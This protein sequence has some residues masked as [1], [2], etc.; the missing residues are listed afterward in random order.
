MAF[1]F[2]HFIGEQPDGEQVYFSVSQDGLHWIDL[3][4]GKPVLKSKIGAC[5]VRDPFIVKHPGTGRYYLMS[6]DLRIASGITW[7]Q[8]KAESSRD[9]I[10][11]KSDD[12]LHW[13]DPQACTV[14]AEGVGCV[15]APE[16]IYDREKR[17]F[18]LF[19]ASYVHVLDKL[20]IYGTFTSDFHV[21]SEPFVNLER[22]RSVIDTTMIEINGKYYRI[23][24]NEIECTL[25]LEVSDS[26]YQHFTRIDS[27]VLRDLH[28][29]DGPE[30]YPLPDGKSY[31][32]IADQFIA[33]KGY[34]PLISDDLISGAFSILPT[35]HYD[36]GQTHK[37]HGGVIFI[38]DQEYRALIQHFSA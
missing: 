5:G 10:V 24:K 15:W 14:G 18:F 17:Q 23:S 21:Y 11:W 9:I 28:G 37:R 20:R 27:A 4:D 1:L 35:D 8:A 6:T 38:S 33:R 25:E 16:A 30:I 29:V 13:S 32:L 2:A 22:E 19:F 12:L 26:P 34:L 31:C 7:Q 3:Y 36:F